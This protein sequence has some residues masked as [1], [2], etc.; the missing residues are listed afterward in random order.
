MNIRSAN[1]MDIE[2]IMELQ[3]Q[4]FEIHL[5]ARPE[6]IKKNPINYDYIKSIIESKNG[7]IFIVEENNKII[8]HCIISIREIKNNV[9]FEDMTNIEID[10]MCINEQ[11]RKK[12][13]G[14]KLFE[15]VKIYAKE[16]NANYI[17][18]MVWDFNQNAMN[19]YEKMGMKTR[20][21]R[22]EYKV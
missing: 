13:I 1:T 15:E 3:T 22:M 18:L 17:E 16:I 10:E 2:K 20:I 4:V 19:F 11:F 5:K 6:W 14:K 21:R 8:G 9:I 12:G 7:K